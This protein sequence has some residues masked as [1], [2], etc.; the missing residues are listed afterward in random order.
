MIARFIEESEKNYEELC[1]NKNIIVYNKKAD[2]E[3]AKD[4]VNQGCKYM[5]LR[6]SYFMLLPFFSISYSNDFRFLSS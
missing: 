3:R 2:Y 6:S 5:D 4:V 1:S